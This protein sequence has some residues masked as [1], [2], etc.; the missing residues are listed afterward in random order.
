MKKASLWVAMLAATLI[1]TSYAEVNLETPEDKT[2]YS[3]GVDIGKHFQQQDIQIKM[4]SFISGVKDGQEG[5]EYQ[6]SD[7]EIR[8]TLIGLQAKI[9]EKQNEE[10]QDLAQKNLQEGKAFLDNHKEKEGVQTTASGLQYRIIEEGQGETPDANDRVTTNY[11]GTLIDG[12]EF[13]SSYK[14]GEPMEFPVNGVIPGWTEALQMMKAGAKWELV[15]PPEL[16]YGEH[17]VGNIIGP[18]AT[19]IFEIELLEVHK[20]A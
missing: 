8:D 13:D 16:A 18:N 4:D 3:I 15:V 1:P 12:T 9:L 7:Q 20:K 10:R 11:R 6:L 19:L 14:R 2:S 17:G 5:G